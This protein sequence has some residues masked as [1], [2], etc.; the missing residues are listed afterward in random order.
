MQFIVTT[1][2]GLDQLLMDECRQLLPESQLKLAPGRVILEGSLADAYH[3]CLGSRLANRVLAVMTSGVVKNQDDLYQLTQTVQWPEQFAS[4]STFMVQFNG[5]NRWLKNTQFG[6]LKVKDGIVDSFVEAGLRRPDV[7]KQQPQI[8]INARLHKDEVT[9]CIDLSGRSLHQR[10]YRVATGEAPVKEHIAAAMLHRA[11]IADALTKDEPLV[12]LDPMCG[13]GTLI[14]EAVNMARRIAPG[15]ARSKWGFD[16]WLGHQQSVFNDIVQTFI[17]AQR[18]DIPHQFYANDVDPNTLRI[19]KN[20]AGNAQVMRYIRFSQQDAS[21]LQAPVS[22]KLDED[23]MALTPHWLIA[24]PPYGERLGELPQLLGLFQRWGAHLKQEYAGWQVSLLSS[25]RDILRQLRLRAKKSYKVMNGK[26]ECEIVNYALDTNNC[27]HQVQRDG[28]DAFANRIAKN[29]K[30][31]KPWLKQHQTD[32]Y[33]MYDADLPEYNCAID[34]YGDWLIVQEYAAPK[35]IPEAKAKAR[36]HDII[37]QLP[38]ATG[39]TPDKIALKVRE[40]QKGKAQYERLKTHNNRFIV[41]EHEAMFYV[42]PTDYLDVGLFLD[43]RTTRQLF[44]AEAK[45]K[46]VLN[47][48]CYTGSVSVHAA[49]G[50][51]QTV[52]S[53]DMSNTYLQWAKDNFRLNRLQGGYGFTQGDCVAWLKDN[54]Q[55]F[56]LMFIDPPSFSNSKRMEG[57]WDVQRDHVSL[58]TSAA[59]SLTS[60]GVVY[61][62]NNLRGFKLDHNA[63]EQIGYTI[64]NISERTLP[65]D[66]ARNPKIHQCWRLVYA[67]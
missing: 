20:N 21:T 10:D 40:Q 46:R 57:T 33:R 41:H 52:M 35:D 47:L 50:G 56:D 14:I 36:L 28:Q 62:S 32:C 49:K 15:L 54:T 19:A 43:H 58:L 66:F 12:L 31:L 53:V 48:F 25:N 22:P 13:S 45:G 29:L 37:M 55:P 9:L 11:G 61:F 16:A 44:K 38:I 67:V 34:R 60:K 51:A 42:N 24:N 4:S 18:L 5:T 3:L 26:L 27:S 7:A 23:G 64:E 8:I 39:V 17:D 1:S 30:K 6:A 65:K 2:S 59:E 63:L